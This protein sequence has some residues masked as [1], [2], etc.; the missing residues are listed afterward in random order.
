MP[1]TARHISHARD[2]P[3]YIVFEY[4]SCDRNETAKQFF[5][6]STTALRVCVD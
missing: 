3:C 6:I 4:M 5:F 2:F 1:P